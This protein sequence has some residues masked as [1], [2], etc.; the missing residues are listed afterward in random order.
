MSER[1]W[2]AM[3]GS[4]TVDDILSIIRLNCV[5]LLPVLNCARSF[6]AHLP[7]FI[8]YGNQFLS[9]QSLGEHYLKKSLFV[10]V[11]VVSKKIENALK[12]F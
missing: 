6:I 5:P 2:S 3:H 12:A 1:F 7:P 11:H 8:V 10:Y 9:I 4:M